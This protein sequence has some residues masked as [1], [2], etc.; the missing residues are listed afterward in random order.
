MVDILVA[1]LPTIPT[2]V[3]GNPVA[4]RIRPALPNSD[5]GRQGRLPVLFNII[6][7]NVSRELV[8]VP[9]TKDP[10]RLA[11]NIQQPVTAAIQTAIQVPGAETQAAPLAWAVL[12]IKNRIAPI[13]S[14]LTENRLCVDP[15]SLSVAQTLRRRRMST[16]LSA[17]PIANE[18]GAF[19]GQSLR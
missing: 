10:L 19:P 8:R 17:T 7:A 13:I 6:R 14:V 3:I 5:L 12:V 18:Q 16:W 4:R 15:I 11:S 9:V 2:D 1:A